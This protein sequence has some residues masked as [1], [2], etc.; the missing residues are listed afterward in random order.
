[1]NVT[2]TMDLDARCD[3][4]GDKG[5]CQNGL[6]LTCAT[7]AMLGKKPMMSRTGKAVREQYKAARE[8]GAKG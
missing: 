3:E 2:I 5:R 6:C 8:E 1:M 4:C 7:K